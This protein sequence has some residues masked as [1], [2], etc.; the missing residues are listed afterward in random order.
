M[1]R[2]L[3]SVTSVLEDPQIRPLVAGRQRAWMT[4]LIQRVIAAQRR[5]LQDV[6]D[7]HAMSRQELLAATVAQVLAER[8]RLLGPTLR[9]VINGTGVVVHTNLGRARYPELAVAW[10]REAALNNVDLEYVL[11]TGQRGHRG[12]KVEAKLALLTGAQDALIV[13][14]NAG[15]IWLAVRSCA[16]SGRVILSRGETVAIGGSFRMHEILQETGCELVE[17]GTTNRTGLGDYRKALVPGAVVLKVHRSNFDVVGFTEEVALSEL[18][19]LC[20]EQG[21]T[22][23]YDA[24]SGALHPY[25]ELGLAGETTLAED[26][27]TGA[28]LVTC[29]GDKLLGGCQAGFVLGRADLIAALRD[30]PLRRALRV[31]K[32]TLAAVDAVL[33]LYLGATDRPPLPTLDFVARPLTDLAEAAEKLLAELRPNAPSGW[34]GE[35]VAGESSVGG[36]SFS[37]ASLASRLLLWQGPKVE[38]EACHAQMR[39]DD[40]AVITRINQDGLALDLRTIAPDELPLV[41]QAFRRAWQAAA[42][43]A[44]PAGQDDRE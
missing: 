31:D 2:E 40:P 16:G 43:G 21:H 44:G 8:Q 27:A 5:V 11:E 14:N 20:R 23:L 4:R 7:T 3:P 12:R 19:S 10:A 15:A 24:G 38:L 1:L 28:D 36:G 18:A 34:H 37:N 42:D 6:P 13:N 41:A 25:E 33:T 26:L 17:V 32:T 35:V 39:E 9:R 29:S 30:H 22:L